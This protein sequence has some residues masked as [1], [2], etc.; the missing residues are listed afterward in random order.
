M[1][2]FSIIVAATQRGGIGLNG[3]LPWGNLKSDLS[4]FK[5]TTTSCMSNKQNAIIMG[6]KTWTSIGSPLK[7]RLNIILTRSI[8]FGEKLKK[9]FKVEVS[10]NLSNA[11]ILASSKKFV[12]KIFII[13]G[14]EIYNE[15]MKSD[16]CETIYM[17]QILKD[18][19]TDIKIN[20]I[21]T[22]LFEL[23]NIGNVIFEND[24]PFQFLTYNRKY[25]L[26]KNITN[27]G[28]MQYLN[29]IEDILLNGN[30]REDRTNI[31][32]LS[33]FGVQMKFNLDGQF[34]LLTTK[35]VF[36]KAVVEELL[37]MISGSTDSKILSKKNIRIWD[38]NSSREFLDNL[39]FKDREVG[40][41][42]PV[43][44]FQWRHFGATYIN[45]KT[46][47]KNKG[48]DQ[49]KNIINLIKKDPNSRRIILSAWNVSDINI[50]ALPPCH[51]LSQFYVHNGY[52]SCQLYQ[53]SGDMGLGVPFNIASYSLLTYILAK[54]CDLKP[55][56]FI[57]TI[58]DAHIYLNHVEALKEQIKRIPKSFP[59]LI[60]NNIKDID[61]IKPEDIILKNYDPHGSIKMEMAI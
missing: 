27:H 17:T 45:Y 25:N 9:N 52:L 19:E 61:N 39:G 21:N 33:K 42:G 16:Y 26:E 24:I 12:D 49:L 53:R 6:S 18:F 35:K 29:L 41:L 15:A 36:F 38:G 14:A 48:N 40:D 13:G 31:G 47:Y 56:E 7:N 23:K 28:E 8:D 59:Q 58:G 1:K 22:N 34:P 2:S 32:T 46:D 60:I 37:W 11:L 50:M 30:K 4:F 10:N 57:H 5:K 43:Y 20:P 44:G 51:I 54:L 55:G 3:K